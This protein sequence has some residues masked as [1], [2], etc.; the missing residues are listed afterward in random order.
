MRMRGGTYI[1]VLASYQTSTH[2]VAVRMREPVAT[3]TYKQHGSTVG[4]T[5]STVRIARAP[6][7]M[8]GV[9]TPNP[10]V[11]LYLEGQSGENRHVLVCGQNLNLQYGQRAKH[12]AQ[13][14][15]GSNT[16]KPWTCAPLGAKRE[17]KRE[18]ERERERA[19]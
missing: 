19:P 3:S 17:R 11:F 14:G 18:R 16:N 5:Y 15:R 2:A 13:N 1:A 7:T 8:Q 10:S 4:E 6:V 9:E 12:P